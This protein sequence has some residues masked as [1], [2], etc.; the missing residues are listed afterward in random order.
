V[1]R[2]CACRGGRNLR[3]Q[4]CVE[5]VAARRVGPTG[6]GCSQPSAARQRGDEIDGLTAQMTT[7]SD[8]HPG[9]ALPPG[10]AERW[11][12]L[13]TGCDKRIDERRELDKA[14]RTAIAQGVIDGTIPSARADMPNSSNTQQIC[15]N[16]GT[17]KGRRTIDNAFNA[18]QLP[19]ATAEKATALITEGHATDRGLADRWATAAGNPEYLGAFAKLCGD[20]ERGHMLWTEA[21]AAAYRAVGSVGSEL[22]NMS[23]TGANGGF[24]VR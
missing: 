10:A 5:V 20:P 12:N 11:Q 9:K 7:I 2:L 18:G 21:E 24:M 14:S 19:A 6:V 15:T 13:S 1:G 16:A 8:A 3:V 23:T 17:D 22:R 4:P